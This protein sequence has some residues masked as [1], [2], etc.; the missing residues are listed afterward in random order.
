MLQYIMML[1]DQYEYN[2]DNREIQKAT[3]GILKMIKVSI[4]NVLKATKLITKI[5]L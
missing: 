2:V 5:K 1:K 3:L 4:K